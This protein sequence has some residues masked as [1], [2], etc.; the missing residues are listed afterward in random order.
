MASLHTQEAWETIHQP[1]E[2]A[3]WKE[4]VPKGHLRD[5]Q[6]LPFVEEIRDWVEPEGLILDIGSG[7]RPFFPPC[8]V[9]EPLAD[10]YRKFTPPEWWENVAV[11]NMAAENFVLEA[12]FNTIICWNCID[13]TPNWREML[14]VMVR[15]ATPDA[16]IA[17]S[18]DFHPPFVGHP[19]FPRDVFMHEITE[20]F[21]VVK[22]KEPFGRAL[23]MMLTV[24]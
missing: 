8:W 3:W 4:H 7:P 24:K 22:T 14:D 16:R 2:L 13:H 10:E 20:R 15:V 18:T 5:E 1:F 6:F 12:K 11:F 17:L 23:A 9:I 19:G 21:N